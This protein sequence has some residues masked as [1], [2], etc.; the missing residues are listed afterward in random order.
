MPIVAGPLRKFLIVPRLWRLFVCHRRARG[1]S[2]EFQRFLL[3]R[4]AE[5]RADLRSFDKT[6]CFL[7]PL[8]PHRSASAGTT[9]DCVQGVLVV[10]A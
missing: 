2:P 4:S 3:L 7:S 9:A 10:K 6:P 1:R 8:R 5:S